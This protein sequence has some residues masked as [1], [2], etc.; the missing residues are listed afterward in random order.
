MPDLVGLVSVGRV[1]EWMACCAE[2]EEV[3]RIGEAWGRDFDE[4]LQKSFS[5]AVGFFCS[6]EATR[7]GLIYYKKPSDD[8]DIP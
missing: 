2:V 7:I 5:N 8:T 4:R 1:G 6:L 3:G